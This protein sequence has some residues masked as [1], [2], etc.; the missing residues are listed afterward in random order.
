MQTKKAL[1][2][3]FGTKS[4]RNI[5]T[6]EPNWKMVS[7]QLGRTRMSNKKKPKNTPDPETDVIKDDDESTLAFMEVKKLILEQG[8]INQKILRKVE[9]VQE[10]QEE[11][12][13]IEE[14]EKKT[15]TMKNQEKRLQELEAKFDDLNEKP[16]DSL[17]VTKILAETNL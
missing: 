7:N 14:L 17:A 15:K 8:K 10:K 9:E 16:V 4:T 2:I 12:Q 13:R 6:L 1:N 5:E 3:I 11:L